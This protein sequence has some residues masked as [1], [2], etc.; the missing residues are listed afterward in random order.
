[1]AEQRPADAIVEFRQTASICQPCGLADIAR[2]YQ[3]LG[4]LDSSVAYYE[5][6]LATPDIDRL[7]DDPW[8]LANVYRRL[9]QLHERWGDWVKASDYYVRF[10][11][12]W[13]DC[14]PDL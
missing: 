6:Y 13:K 5:R 12:L 3:A 9:G 2:A 10:T 1:M 8:R 4:V 7:S 14:D 11:Q